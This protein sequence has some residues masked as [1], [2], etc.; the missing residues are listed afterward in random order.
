MEERYL[1]PLDR[2]LASADNALR[3]VVAPAGY[4]ARPNPAGKE[5]EADL[6]QSQRRHAA[7]LMRVNHAGEVAAQGLYQGHAAVARSPDIEEQMHRAAD[8]EFDHLAWC[9]Q[10]LTELDA[11][12]SV[13]SPVWYAGAFAIG[14]ASGVLG[15]RWSLGFIAETEKQVCAHLDSHLDR[16]PDED[17]K[18]RA[19]VKQMRDEEEEH[20]ANAKKAGA[21]ELPAPVLRLM[22]LTARVMTTTAYRL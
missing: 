13:L 20:G 1:T 4:S 11:R 17:A 6:S 18:S 22:Q 7:G 19:I 12:P 3:T 8:E 9:E 21:A 16:L 10:R 2:L 14:A 5:P 15:D